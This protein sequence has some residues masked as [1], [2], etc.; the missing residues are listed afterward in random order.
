M[1]DQRAA[2]SPQ[3]PERIAQ[4]TRTWDFR[5][6]DGRLLTDT[7]WADA[8]GTVTLYLSYTS[9]VAKGVVYHRG[10]SQLYQLGMRRF[11]RDFSQLT[12]RPSPKSAVE[13]S[14][15]R[16]AQETP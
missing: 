10:G 3:Q 7:E 6:H 9:G 1:T 8:K 14:A 12:L 5:N 4:N 13:L 16:N 11:L 2:T 15:P